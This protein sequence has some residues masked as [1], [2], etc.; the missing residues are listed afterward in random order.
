MGSQDHTQL[1][2]KS[3]SEQISER[4]ALRQ[5]KMRPFPLGCDTKQTSVMTPI[6][7]RREPDTAYHALQSLSTTGEI[8]KR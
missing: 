2:A 8:Q 3:L 6:L 7:S 4:L 1:H 5:F